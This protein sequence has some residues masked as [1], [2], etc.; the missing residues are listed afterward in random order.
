MAHTLDAL[1]DLLKDETYAIS[2]K[3]LTM[4][5]NSTIAVKLMQN[6]WTF[7]H[8]KSIITINLNNLACA[9]FQMIMDKFKQNGRTFELI[10]NDK[11]KITTYK[12]E[13]TLIMHE[14]Q[15]I[16]EIYEQY[17]FCDKLATEKLSKGNYT[18]GLMALTGH[19]H[20]NI[21]KS[22][23]ITISENCSSVSPPNAHSYKP[24]SMNESL[25]AVRNGSQDEL[26]ELQKNGIINPQLKFKQFQIFFDKY[27]DCIK[28][29][30]EDSITLANGTAE[31]S[32]IIV[33][34]G[35]LIRSKYDSFDI[36]QP[37]YT[38]QQ[39]FEKYHKQ[40]MQMISLTPK[41]LENVKSIHM[42]PP[43]I[44]IV[45][46]DEGPTGT[47]HH[48]HIEPPGN[49]FEITRNLNFL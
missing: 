34:F 5:N 6:N 26:D 17:I 9:L 35:C 1:F 21:S 7:N 10:N 46:H 14:G 2:N 3:V 38:G 15:L 49:L 44:T 32:I 24:W 20:V 11:L 45:T 39:I 33:N 16:I 23:Q 12:N 47:F 28:D 36:T 37:L 41:F 40:I 29:I 30:S 25:I 43:H 4:S 31:Y 27:R 19:P 22:N 18:H 8:T 42:T 13:M 48:W